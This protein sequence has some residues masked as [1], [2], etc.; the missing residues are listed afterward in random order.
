VEGR[1]EKKELK[2]NGKVKQ[3]ELGVRSEWRDLVKVDWE[4]NGM[5]IYVEKKGALM[6]MKFLSPGRRENVAPRGHSWYHTHLLIF[7]G[8]LG[9]S[10]GVKCKLVP[11]RLYWGACG[12]R[13]LEERRLGELA[14]L[15]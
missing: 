14:C 7:G 13:G 5:Q 12:V 8:K 15:Q 9:S 3:K 4:I 2:E 6:P 1:A 10:R 11:R